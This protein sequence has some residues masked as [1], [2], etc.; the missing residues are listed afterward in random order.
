MDEEL[1]GMVGDEASGIVESDAA[2][3]VWGCY[4]E[5]EYWKTQKRRNGEDAVI[6]LIYSGLVY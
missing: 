6:G 2:S 3:S 5:R 4:G 1:P